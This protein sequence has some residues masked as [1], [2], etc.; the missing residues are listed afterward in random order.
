MEKNSTP[1]ADQ[2]RR[3]AAKAHGLGRAKV[4]NL[5]IINATY[6]QAGMFMAKHPFLKQATL[7]AGS[8]PGQTGPIDSVG[9]WPFVL[10]RASL[11]K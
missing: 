11:L 10:A 4:N 2:P 9:S 5:R 6:S 8:Y 7:P 3:K 1:R